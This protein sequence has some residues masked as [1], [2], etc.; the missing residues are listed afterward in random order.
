MGIGEIMVSIHMV[1]ALAYHDLT[2]YNYK[3]ESDRHASQSCAPPRRVGLH[4][5]AR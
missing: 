3:L 5:A 2:C 4:A 1:C